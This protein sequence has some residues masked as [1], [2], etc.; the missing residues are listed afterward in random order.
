MHQPS[1]DSTSWARAL[2]IV[3]LAIAIWAAL[4][5]VT[6]GFRVDLGPIRISSR[7]AIRAFLLS[8]VPAALAWR[9]AYQDWLEARVTRS[10]PVLRQCAVVVVVLL[11]SAVLAAGVRYGSRAAAAS[12]ASGYASQSALWVQGTLKIAQSF[13]ASLPWPEAKHSFTPL[14]YRAGAGDAMVPTYAPG[15]PLLMA[16]ARLVSSC[17]PYL[18][19]PLCCALFVLFTFH[20]GRQVFGTATGVVASAL[21]ACSPV[22]LFMSFMP[23]ADLPAAACWT[24]ALAL[25]VSGTPRAS[26]ASGVLTGLAVLIRPNLVPLAVF[27]WAMTIL[28]CQALRPMLVRTALFA[29]GSVP[30][31]LFIAWFNNLLYGSPL[32]SGYGDLSSGFALHYGGINLKRYS[33]WWLESQG[34]LAFLFVAAFFR[35]RQNMAREFR[36]LVAFGIALALLYL[37]YIPFEAW[38]FLRFLLPGVP[39]IFLLCA[40]V[41]D[42]ASRGSI[43]VKIAALAA[44]TVAA[45]G[46]AARFIDTHDIGGIGVGEQRYVEPALYI[47]DR[48]PADAIVLT[49]QHS[50]SL[51]YHSGRLTMRWDAID[52]AWLDRAIDFL[53]D[54]GIATYALLEYWEEPQFRERFKG[55]R[56][57]DELDLGPLATGRAGEQR[58]YPLRAPGSGS[59][60]VP[61]T[62]PPRPD[63]PCLEISHDYEEPLAV[64][65]LR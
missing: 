17:G 48:T 23:M 19:G 53:Q 63:R 64:R 38:W 40:D 65:R 45:G 33:S 7:N 29:A 62:I 22:V 52:P 46:H 59:R 14:G 41:I 10:L 49:M 2:L 60:R 12:D 37:F 13:T 61:E 31:A 30:A 11:A 5:A 4:I 18:V 39:L 36:V 32:T 50:G 47:A 34:P 51:R 3:S 42:W 25:A 8:L 16:A 55:Q 20:L 24:G 43:A 26:L 28:R 6:G 15:V 35:R 1:R 21:V 54:R 9:L 57:L 27:P 44:F 58:F 56:V